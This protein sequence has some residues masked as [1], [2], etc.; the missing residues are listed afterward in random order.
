MNKFYISADSTDEASE[1][2]LKNKEISYNAALEGIVLLRNENK[3]LPVINNKIALFGAG[4]RHASKGGTGSGE[5]NERK[6]TSIYDGLLNEKYIITTNRYLDEYDALL[7]K[8]NQ[9]ND[10]LQKLIDAYMKLQEENELLK[11]QL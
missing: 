4:A 1:L 2:E 6:V 11:S 3:V 10:S 9:L 5:V 7:D 8:N